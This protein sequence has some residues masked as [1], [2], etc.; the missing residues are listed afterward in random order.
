MIDHTLVIQGLTDFVSHQVGHR[1]GVA[2]LAAPGGRIY[3]TARYRRYIKELRDAWGLQDELYTGA[4]WIEIRFHYPSTERARGPRTAA[5]DLDN[6]AKSV[7]DAL[8]GWV[9]KNDA[10]VSRLQIYKRNVGSQDS[11][12]SVRIRTDRGWIDDD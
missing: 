6:L 3:S 1:K 2:R 7:L 9:I 4:L 10:S 12:L 8:E 5:P 11:V